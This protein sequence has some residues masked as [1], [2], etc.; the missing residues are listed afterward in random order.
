LPGCLLEPVARFGLFEPCFLILKTLSE[1]I[2][3]YFFSGK[4]QCSRK[5][6]ALFGITRHITTKASS[7]WTTTTTADHELHRYPTVLCS[8]TL[9][10]N[11]GLGPW[12]YSVGFSELDV[13]IK[14]RSRTFEPKT[15]DIATI[16][17][18]FW[19]Q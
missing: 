16:D 5:S 2:P 12:F 11:N 19:Y 14:K 13:M 3:F 9:P 6:S 7:V 15:N 10:A 1:A 4:P 8:G 18:T 17:I